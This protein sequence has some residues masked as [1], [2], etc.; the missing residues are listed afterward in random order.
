M[1]RKPKTPA[2]DPGLRPQ[3]VR[4]VGRLPK[5]H[6]VPVLEGLDRAFQAEVSTEGFDAP[7]PERRV[8][9]KP[10]TWFR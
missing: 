1:S 9:W 6:K 3:V 8:W 4:H 5:L 10:W 7:A 2:V